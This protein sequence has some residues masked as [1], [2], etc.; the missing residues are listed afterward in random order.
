MML[1]LAGAVVGI[2]SAG[3][4]ATPAQGHRACDFLGWESRTRA[5]CRKFCDTIVVPHGALAERATS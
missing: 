2:G 3:F 4:L 5:C 1:L